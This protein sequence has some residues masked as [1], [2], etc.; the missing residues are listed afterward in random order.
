MQ[1]ST[2]TFTAVAAAGAIAMLALAGCSSDPEAE[3]TGDHGGPAPQSNVYEF[4][5]PSHA[6][7]GEVT[8]QIPDGLRGVAGSDAEKLLVTS[9][10]A[11]PHELE[12]AKY[13]AV[14]L[15]IE[16]SNGAPESL[17]GETTKETA[18]EQE[19]SG[20]EVDRI[21]KAMEAGTGEYDDVIAESGA[22]TPIQLQKY[23]ELAKVEVETTV[24]GWQ[25]LLNTLTYNRG[26]A[27]SEL[28]TSDPE[29]GQYLSENH[30]TVTTVRSCAKSPMD[31]DNTLSFVLPTSDGDSTAGFATFD[32]A[33]MANGTVA[34]TNGEV[35]DY[36]RDS[37]GD[38]IAD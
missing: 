33:A 1:K 4:K 18:L 38:W 14:D 9:V 25:D 21:V 17:V 28:D 23:L 37:N 10:K 2:K 32:V 8:I 30:K 12:S 13:C 11:T 36:A 20:E 35:E 29:T 19:Y 5:T 6:A 15:A 26:S 22:E 31:D 7:E 27:I 24:P 34:I 3:P 16:Y